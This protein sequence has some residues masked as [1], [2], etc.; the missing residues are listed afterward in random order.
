[1]KVTLIET[2]PY[3]D[4]GFVRPLLADQQTYPDVDLNDPK[5]KIL[6]KAVGW[7]DN[8]FIVALKPRL[9]ALVE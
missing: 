7:G 8:V 5:I 4:R 3:E 6:E 9:Y 1:M 2:E